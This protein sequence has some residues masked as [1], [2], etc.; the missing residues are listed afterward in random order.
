MRVGDVPERPSTTYA[1][2]AGRL[3][4]RVPE[5]VAV[6]IDTERVWAK[7]FALDCE[8]VNALLFDAELKL[9]ARVRGPRSAAVL[10]EITK[11]AGA[12]APAGAP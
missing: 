3:S 7:E 4:G 1:K 5:G 12:L 11:A 2:V 9:V 6:L 10:A 8:E